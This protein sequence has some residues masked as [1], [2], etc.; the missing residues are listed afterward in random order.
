MVA[1]VEQQ[2]RNAV[3]GNADTRQRIFGRK[4]DAL[5]AGERLGLD[6]TVGSLF[7]RPAGMARENAEGAVEKIRFSEVSRGQELKIEAGFAR[8]SGGKRTVELD[9]HAKAAFFRAHDNAVGQVLLGVCERGNQLVWRRPPLAILKLGNGVPLRGS[10]GKTHV[11]VGSNALFVQD[12]F[13]AAHFF[14]AK[15]AVVGIVKHKHAYAM[16]LE[17]ILR[18]EFE[19]ARAGVR[20]L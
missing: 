7:H 4:Q 13:D 10:R 5:A 3:R 9:G 19:C 12:E 15:N 18:G 17:R 2:E 6:R 20:C 11:T 1:A 8:E 14:V 16:R